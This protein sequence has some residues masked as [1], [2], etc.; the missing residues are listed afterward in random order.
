[1]ME[2]FSSSVA[3]SCGIK[4]KLLNGGHLLIKSE[5]SPGHLLQLAEENKGKRLMKKWTVIFKDNVSLL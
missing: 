4:V 2:G 3:S 1:M 5:M